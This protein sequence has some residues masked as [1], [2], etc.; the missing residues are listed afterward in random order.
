[1][2]RLVC[3]HV[4]QPVSAKPRLLLI[5]HSRTGS[6]AH[7]VAAMSDACAEFEVELVCKPA[8]ESQADDVLRADA[9]IFACPENLASMSGV[10]KDF[11]DRSYYALLD[12][13]AAKPYACLI[14]AGS[15]GTSAPRQI[16]RIATGLRLKKIADTLI[17]LTHAQSA[18]QIA[19]EKTLTP[20]QLT[21]VQEL[22]K[23]L[24]AGLALGVF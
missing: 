4:G 2:A 13:V 12:R 17:L 21:Q 24:A 20:E 9:V 16:E 23:T 6:I 3:Q 10:M 19:A 14:A 18:E 22:A 15:D 8:H 7:A 5:W 11:F 1:M